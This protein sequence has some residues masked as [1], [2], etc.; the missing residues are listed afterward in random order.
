MPSTGDSKHSTRLAA[1]LDILQ[2][3]TGLLL[4]L[5]MWVH[6]L[7]VSSILLGKDAMHFVA[8][9][10]EGEPLFGKSYPI[11]VSIFASL[12]LGTVVVHATLA[13][14]R[15]PA[16]GA[17]YQILHQH[18]SGLRHRDSWF[19]YIQVITGLLL[20]FL[21]SMHLFQMILHPADIGPYE[22]A[23]RVWSGRMWPIYLTLLFV[24]EIHGGIG[25]YRLMI[26][27]GLFLGGAPK[28]AR[29]RL[30]RLKWLITTFFLILGLLTLAAYMKLGYEHRHQVGERY[31]PLSP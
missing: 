20:L 4:V 17:Q 2:G 28:L 18:L 12:I 6:M 1:W 24:V 15:L 21:T 13:L 10:F 11:L 16:S 3:T 8:R 23:D 26:K 30:Q 19:W 22:S 29:R 31:I 7:M 25:L 5:F 14:R 9:M 27:W